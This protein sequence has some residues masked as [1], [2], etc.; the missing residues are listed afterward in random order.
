MKKILPTLVLLLALGAGGTA[1]YLFQK[2]AHGAGP[3]GS[4][5]E[6]LP[7]DTQL[8]LSVPDLDGTL[9]E[10]KSTDLYKIWSEP[11]M[12]AFLARPLSKL[13]PQ[14]EFGD[15]L[16]KIVHLSPTNIFVALTLPD[17]KSTRP[18]ALA[19]F[20]FKG[21]K[22]EVE[23]LLADSKDALR[24]NF[25]AGKADLLEYQGHSFETF[26]GGDGNAYAA[27]YLDHRY[28]IAND[29]A[30][31]KATIDR[32]DHRA[33]AAGAPGTLE[34]EQDF[35]TVLAKLPS[36][37]ATII[38]G[39]P[40]AALHRLLDL[41]A[42]SGQ[43]LDDA[44]RAELQKVKAAG[45]TTRIESGKLR[46]SVYLLAP[47]I[48]HEA[49][50][51]ALGALPLTSPN[52]LVYAAT[53]F[54]LPTQFDL[55][56]GPLPPG[57]PASGLLTSLQEFA[58]ILHDH[59]VTLDWFH[60]A[61]GNELSAHLDWP[62]DRTQPALL[63]SVDVRDHVA[64]E[65]FVSDLTSTPFAEA[66]WQ[67]SQANGLTFHM[68]S[69]AKGGFVN[70]TLTLTDKHLVLGLN[71][72]E[73]REAAQREQLGGANFTGSDA[74]KT[75]LASVTAPNA[76]FVYIDAPAFFERLYGTLRG[77]A[78]FSAMFY[79]HVDDYVDLTK[80]P[81]TKTVSQHLS[82]T[83]F[84]QRTDDQGSFLESVGSVTVGQVGFVV[85]G[86][87]MAAAFPLLQSQF[88]AAGPG[89]GTSPAPLPNAPPPAP[90]LALP[91]P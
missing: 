11:E 25:P 65:K 35:Q 90:A 83:V 82:P 32:C 34:K 42:A 2:Q 80:L 84:S 52:T 5:A 13:P 18:H 43:P 88:E 41:A 48:E 78:M 86:G 76:S 14:A 67:T 30:L 49:A 57:T 55:P 58:V 81:A 6:Y 66:A 19:G 70:P 74:Y 72:P 28:L 3:A 59:H 51:L 71:P 85:L 22:A 1:L 24:K 87:S 69:A 36:Q 23:Q 17:E 89:V 77:L 68:L 60:A 79:P 73:V 15:I 91:T 75:T 39:R 20:D 56:S 40:Q 64:A 9:A 29:V 7:A 26:D 31:L 12:Q 62:P 63:I 16:A 50:K 21:D 61:F 54:E 4:V 46:D 27:A 37:Y 47:G 10:W 53:V 33:P 8:L 45:A 38:F 44:R